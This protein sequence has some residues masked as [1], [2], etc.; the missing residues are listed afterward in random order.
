M[1]LMIRRAE[2]IDAARLA[3]FAA[4]TFSDTYAAY[5]DPADMAEHLRAKYGEA[6][7]AAEIRDPTATYLLAELEG[8]LAGFAFLHFEHGPDGVA[9]E[10]PV[11]LVRFYVAREWHGRGVAQMLMAG[12]V[13]DARQRGAG[14]LWLSVWEEN[15]RAISFYRKS[16][17]RLAGT[18][19]FKLGSQLQ[20]DHMMTL[21]LVPVESRHPVG[22]R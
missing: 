16:G 10:R 19:R 17:F 12:C 22:P 4:R 5:N 3:S 6:I 7:Q 2:P 20:D 14:T 18:V 13:Q 21:A 8:E 15:S 9:L 1:P 11:E